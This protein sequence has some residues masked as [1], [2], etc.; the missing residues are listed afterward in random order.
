MAMKG[1]WEGWP[2]SPGMSLRREREAAADLVFQHRPG[3]YGFLFS[4]GTLWALFDFPAFC[5]ALY[6][7]LRFLESGECLDGE[8]IGQVR[9][10]LSLILLVQLL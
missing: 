5:S 10:D 7:Q 6:P 4:R 9:N 1:T 3:L 2:R 8:P